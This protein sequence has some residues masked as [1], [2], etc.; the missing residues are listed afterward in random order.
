MDT[1]SWGEYDASGD[2]IVDETKETP[3]PRQ[4]ILDTIADAH[5]GR[6]FSDREYDELWKVLGTKEKGGIVKGRGGVTWH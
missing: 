6:F 2:V 4:T 3:I 5:E 1:C